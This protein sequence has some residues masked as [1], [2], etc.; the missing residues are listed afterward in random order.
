MQETSS[1]THHG[2]QHPCTLKSQV[3]PHIHGFCIHRVNQPLIIHISTICIKKSLHKWTHMVQTHIVQASTV[4]WKSQRNL[5]FLYNFPLVSPKAIGLH[6][7]KA[8]EWKATTCQ[9]S[10]MTC[11][12]RKHSSFPLFPIPQS[13]TV[14]REL[15]KPT[16]TRFVSI[17]CDG[18]W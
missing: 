4:L 12:H 3:G 13:E 11:K 2:Y 18:R 15:W 6:T 7:I 9:N 16:G 10:W 8:T 17:T 5:N 14:H 1:R